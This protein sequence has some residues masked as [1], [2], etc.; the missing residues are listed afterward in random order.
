VSWRIWRWWLAGIILY[1][2]FLLATLP[3]GYATAWLQK[4]VPQ[5]QLSG[6]NGS[7]WSGSAREVAWRGQEWGNLHWG[8]DWSALFSGHPGYRLELDAADLALRTRVA[9]NSHNLLLRDIT[10]HLDIARL[11]PWLPLP[12][13]SVAGQLNLQ[14][15]RLLLVNGQPTA[16]AG[17]ISLSSFNLMWPQPVALG[18]YEMKL[19]T[20]ADGIHGSMLDTSGPLI[21]QGSLRFAPDGSYQVS[22]TLSARDPGNTPIA[23]LLRYL[24]A[25]QAGDRVF[26]FSGKDE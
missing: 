6:V 24:P 3:A 18:D 5:L 25:D 19:Q 17:I 9:G 26:A 13:G 8:F 14:L 22:G 23:N 2:I 10:G 20:Q 7:L 4:R 11:E 1:L 16:A 21:L 15:Q 12:H